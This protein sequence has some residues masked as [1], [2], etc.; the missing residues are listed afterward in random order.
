M[1]RNQSCP[2]KQYFDL[3]KQMLFFMS[4]K[5]SYLCFFNVLNLI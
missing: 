3:T 4:S 5:F 2:F 1:I